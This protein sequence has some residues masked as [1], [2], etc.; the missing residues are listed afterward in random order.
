MNSDFWNYVVRK[1]RHAGNLAEPLPLEIERLDGRS[2][3]RVE[4]RLV[5]L[6]RGGMQV[7]APLPLTKGENLRVHLADEHAP[8]FQTEAV[9][10]WVRLTEDGLAWNLGLQFATELQLDTLG[11]LFLSHVLDEQ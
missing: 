3:A 10:R 8:E 4:A 2:P 9:V 1:P 5:D 11:E 6:S 7:A